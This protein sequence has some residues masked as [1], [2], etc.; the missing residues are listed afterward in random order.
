MEPIDYFA[1]ISFM[2]KKCP[3]CES[4]IEFG[5]TTKWDDSAN[6]HTCNGCGSVVE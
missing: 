4:K 2:E 5:L 3:Q 6:A 1:S